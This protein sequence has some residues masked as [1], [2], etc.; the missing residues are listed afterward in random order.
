MVH[1][2]HR[3]THTP[4]ICQL[5]WDAT[6]D[7]R[8]ILGIGHQYVRR[9]VLLSNLFS[10]KIRLAYRTAAGPY[11][12]TR[13]PGLIAGRVY[14]HPGID[15]QKRLH[16]QLLRGTRRIGYVRKIRISHIFGIPV[17]SPFVRL[18]PAVR[19]AFILLFSRVGLLLFLLFL[20]R[21]L[22]LLAGDRQPACQPCG[23]QP[24]RHA[25]NALPPH[26]S[27]VKASF[28]RLS[29]RFQSCA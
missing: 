13:H 19:T 28:M 29:L 6:R 21:Q 26:H 27:S 18:V 14:V 24:R 5:Q 2:I 22:H 7:I 23:T 25:E 20:L 3:L 16:I 4:V 8:H 9:Q 12:I 11:N 17:L 10:R 15:G 1:Q